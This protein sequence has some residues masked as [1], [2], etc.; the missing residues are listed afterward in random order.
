MKTPFTRIRWSAVLLGLAVAVGV[1]GAWRY[2]HPKPDTAN[3]QL[4][5][6]DGP[7]AERD[8]AGGMKR[9][10]V[11]GLNT[12]RP[13]LPAQLTEAGVSYFEVAGCVPPI[14]SIAGI[15]A[16]NDQMRI[17]L[18]RDT[19]LDLTTFLPR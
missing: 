18:Q 5:N 7:M 2:T 15:R 6:Y 4:P 19:G 13:A 12:A 14:D 16:Y 3:V 1:W 8:Y 17:L 10:L 11:Y 9:F